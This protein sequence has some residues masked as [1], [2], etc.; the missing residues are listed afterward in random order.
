[1]ILVLSSSKLY[2]KMTENESQTTT[3]LLLCFDVSKLS[4]VSQFLLS[5]TVVLACFLVYGYFL[6]LL[7]RLEGMKDHSW[8]LTMI[9]FLQ[10]V[11]FGLF[12]RSAMGYSNK[13]RRAP[14]SIYMLLA[15]LTVATIGFSNM[16]VGY[17]NYPTQVIFKCCKLIPVLIGG[18]V[19]QGK[20]YGAI[21]FLACLSMSVGLILF[22]LA[23]SEVQPNFNIYGVI[24]ISCALCADA[25]I[26]NL[27]EKTLKA[28]TASN[29]EMIL[30]SYGIGFIYILI[31]LLLFQRFVPAFIFFYQHPLETYGY[32]VIFSFSGYIGVNAVLSQ[33]KLFGALSAVT[34]T[35]FRK[36]ITIILSFILFS[37]PF[38]IRYVWSGLIVLAGI[39]LNLYSKNKL[40]VN[41]KIARLFNS[42]H[43]KS[44]SLVIEP[45]HDNIV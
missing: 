9:Q 43:P 25:V 20:K 32:G 29:A 22:T 16:S 18:I 44:R 7:F 19:I 2:Y 34:V 33:V 45:T 35:T 42:I 10:Y 8:Y 30:Y 38:T 36:M 6:E 14:L 3:E 4:R 26:G 41:G 28:W 40:Y 23:D 24:I 31:G 15:A 12:E 39:Y 37:K 21:D 13:Q 17:L 5:S 11:I 1:M 27:Q